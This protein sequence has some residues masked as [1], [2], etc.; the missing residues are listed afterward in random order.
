MVTRI[1]IEKKVDKVI[2]KTEPVQ[3]IIK[4]KTR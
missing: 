1:T 4:K 3:I 2:V